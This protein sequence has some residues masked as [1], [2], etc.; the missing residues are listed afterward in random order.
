MGKRRNSV[1]HYKARLVPRDL[2]SRL[3]SLR[4]IAANYNLDKIF[5]ARRIELAEWHTAQ[6]ITPPAATDE[7]AYEFVKTFVATYVTYFGRHPINAADEVADIHDLLD[8]VLKAEADED[9][10]RHRLIDELMSNGATWTD[11][12]SPLNVGAF[13]FEN[14]GELNSMARGAMVNSL[15]NSHNAWNSRKHGGKRK[16]HKK[17]SVA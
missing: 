4:E 2:H 9:E 15:E 5:E 16:K 1:L 17:K 12:G 13:V 3:E 14:W 6:G 7:N 11:T 10:Q 8:G